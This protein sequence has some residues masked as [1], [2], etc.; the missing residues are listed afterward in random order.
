[1]EQGGLTAYVVQDGA[2]RAVHVPR[3]LSN[4]ATVKRGDVREREARLVNICLQER[5]LGKLI[6][7]VTAAMPSES[8][9]LVVPDGVL[10]NLPLHIIQTKGLETSSDGG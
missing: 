9:L 4:L 3:T 6:E 2:A 1:M 10:H 5:L 8:R 7:A